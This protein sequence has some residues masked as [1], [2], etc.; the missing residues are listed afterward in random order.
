MG[1]HADFSA[2]PVRLTCALIRRLDSV[3]ISVEYTSYLIWD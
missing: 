3:V 1:R 2:V